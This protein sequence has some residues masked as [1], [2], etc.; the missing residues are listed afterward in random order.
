MG[1]FIKKAILFCLIF[2]V[3]FQGVTILLMS[4]TYQVSPN[5]NY[6]FSPYHM[7]NKVTGFYEIVKDTLDVVFLGS[8][9]VHTNVNP[10]VIYNK[11]G[12]TSY[13]FTADS[14]FFLKNS[15]L[16]LRITLLIFGRFL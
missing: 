4:K 11:Y 7:A 1:K 6:S 12:I 13:D 8:S 10:L 9:H 14:V 3:L 2:A 5:L 15:L 16:W